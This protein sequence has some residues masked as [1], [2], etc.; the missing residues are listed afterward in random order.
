MNISQ[1]ILGI[2]PTPEGLSVDPCLPGFLTE[3]T[4][5]R[6]Y[7]GSLYRIHVKQTGTK[8]LSVDGVPLAGNLLPCGNAEYLVEATV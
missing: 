8:F 1:Y 4:V 5:L 7:R 6:R 3:Y 2:K